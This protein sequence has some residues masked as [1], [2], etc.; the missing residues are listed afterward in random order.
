MDAGCS[1]LSVV[2]YLC[3]F[4]RVVEVNKLSL[5]RESISMP[6]G[7]KGIEGAFST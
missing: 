6:K 4:E 1:Y 5:K 3:G 2:S 7:M